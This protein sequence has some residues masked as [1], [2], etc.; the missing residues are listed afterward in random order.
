MPQPERKGL[1]PSRKHKNFTSFNSSISVKST[2]NAKS[3]VKTSVIRGL[4][5]GGNLVGDA[6]PAPAIPGAR[7]ARRCGCRRVPS[8]LNIRP[9]TP[10]TAAGSSWSRG[11]RFMVTPGRN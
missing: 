1:S 8:P 4:N 9:R 11:P 2:R 7:G 3:L 5:Q 6:A 10:Q